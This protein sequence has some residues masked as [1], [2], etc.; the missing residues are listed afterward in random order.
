MSLE[1]IY[2]DCIL[3]IAS[4]FICGLLL[5]LERKSRQHTV[6]MRTLVLISVSSAVLCMLSI[7]NAMIPGVPEGDPTRITAGIVTGIG[8][9]GG[10]AILHHGLNVRGLTTAAIVLMAMALGVACGAGQYFIAGFSLILVLTSLL[11]LEKIEWKL[12]P[13]EKTKTLTLIYTDS[14]FNFEEIKNTIKKSG[15]MIKDSNIEESVTEN[16][17]IFRF[18]VKA[19]GDFDLLSLSNKLKTNPSLVKISLSEI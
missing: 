7:K 5:G 15:V 10:G 12:F 1:N 3:K 13:A 4:S 11:I 18:S 17:F 14:S 2:L 19:S 9:V 6:G 16:T 8:F